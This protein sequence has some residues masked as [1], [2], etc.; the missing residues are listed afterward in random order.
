MTGIPCSHA[1]SV[2]YYNRDK[3]ENYLHECYKVSTYLETYKHTLFPTHDK[4]SWPK[5]NQG[6]MIPPL[7][8]NKRKGRKTLLR[9]REQDEET[10]A[11]TRGR[12]SKRGVTIKC[13]ICGASGH[14]RRFHDKQKVISIVYVCVYW[15]KSSKLILFEK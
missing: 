13:S 14:N 12:V 10:M 5:S 4:D 3:P 11:F 8:A 7:P 1:I 6:A 9:R 2:I 15:I